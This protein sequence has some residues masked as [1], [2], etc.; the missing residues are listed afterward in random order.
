MIERK[1]ELQRRTA[2]TEI[3]V[4]LNL[5]GQGRGSI[6]TGIGF[7]DHL[8]TALQRHSRFDL[9]VAAAGDL[10]VD[11]HHT[12]EDTG[13]LIGRALAAALGERRGIGRFG[14]AYCPLDEALA[15]TVVDISGRGYLAW[16]CPVPLRPVGQFDGELLPEFLRALAHN[17]GITLH[18]NVLA[19]ENQHHIMEAVIKSL[20]RALRRAAA[21]DPGESGI[22]ST[23]GTLA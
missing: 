18:I 21:I 19:G 1:A 3:R 14:H 9:E 23:K 22:P 13:I 6:D 2:E 5:D 15:R 12:V 7:F 4:A 8:L 17:A 16:S 10:H 11:G 20:A